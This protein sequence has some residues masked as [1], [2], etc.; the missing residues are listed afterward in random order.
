MY[1]VIKTIAVC[2]IIGGFFWIYGSIGANDYALFNGEYMPLSETIKGM[3]TGAGVSLAGW[4]VYRFTDRM[5]KRRNT[6]DARKKR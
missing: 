3:M 4:I 5:S 2:V 1:K 6:G